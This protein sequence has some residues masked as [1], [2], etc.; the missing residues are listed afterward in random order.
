MGEQ[1]KFI[2]YF[3]AAKMLSKC[4]KIVY[5]LTLFAVLYK[6]INTLTT[7]NNSSKNV[8]QLLNQLFCKKLCL[9]FHFKRVRN[10][11]SYEECYLHTHSPLLL[12]E[13]LIIFLTLSIL[14]YCDGLPSYEQECV[15]VAEIKIKLDCKHTN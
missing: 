4:R 7:F 11:S 6:Q 8:L 10:V 13:D 5:S 9:L 1:C 2:G 14:N 15:N 3:G 12:W